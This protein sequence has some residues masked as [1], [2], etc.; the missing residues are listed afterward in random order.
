MAGCQSMGSRTGLVSHLGF[1]SSQPVISGCEHTEDSVLPVHLLFP[2]TLAHHVVTP[3]AAFLEEQAWTSIAFHNPR[4]TRVKCDIYIPS[5]YDWTGCTTLL[6]HMRLLPT[7]RG[8]TAT[9]LMCP[10][11]SSGESC[12]HVSLFDHSSCHPSPMMHYISDS[13]SGSHP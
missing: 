11:T 10:P 9:L 7:N 1:L 13:F 3:I 5:T 4:C 6:V 12:K 2:G 8:S